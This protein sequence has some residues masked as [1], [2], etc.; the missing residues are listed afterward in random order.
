MPC[1]SS[2]ERVWTCSRMRPRS[3]R[4]VR[5]EER[6]LSHLAMRLAHL[7]YSQEAQGP[8][9]TPPGRRA[10]AGVYPKGTARPLL[11]PG[12]PLGRPLSAALL[13]LSAPALSLNTPPILLI[14]RVGAFL[15]ARGITHVRWGLSTLE[16]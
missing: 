14:R 11:R 2:A 1:T 6:R 3:R 9:R 4:Q 7:G 5:G 10:W 12:A 16:T 13:H 8:C 15:L